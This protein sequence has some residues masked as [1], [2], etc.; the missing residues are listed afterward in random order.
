[1]PLKR[2]IDLNT[3]ENLWI[4]ILKVLKEGPSHAYQIR[5]EIRGRFGFS[6]GTVTPYKVLYQLKLKGLVTKREQGRKRVYTITPRG[7]A[8][9]KKAADFYKS[10]IKLLSR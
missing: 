6:P 4:Y 8:E 2:L 7:R 5:K 9:L 10:R 3:K 1:M